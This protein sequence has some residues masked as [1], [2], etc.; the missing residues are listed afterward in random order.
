MKREA[1][2][3]MTKISYN[4]KCIRKEKDCKNSMCIVK[5][6]FVERFEICPCLLIEEG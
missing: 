3:K 6:D 5:Y 2:K 1:E 4:L